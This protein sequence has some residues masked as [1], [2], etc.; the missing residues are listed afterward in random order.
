VAWKSIPGETPIDV[1]GMKISGVAN[2]G[3]LSIVEAENIRKAI[4][5]YFGGPLTRRTAKFD[6]PWMLKLH[7]E[8][9]G[10]VWT[11]AGE[12][13]TANL[14]LGVPWHQIQARMQNLCN[15]LAYW[16]KHWPDSVEQAT[17]LHH[18]AVQ[19]HPFLNGNGRW[20]RLLANIWL[21]LNKQPLT[22]WPEET[23]GETSIIRGE[24]LAAIRAADLG[25]YAP[26]ME[27]HRRYAG[28]GR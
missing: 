14:N 19:I 1:A 11:W 27:L 7:H 13:R 24:Y 9:F 25:D 22:E 8:M 2:R 26:L 12:T 18:R 4:V 10:D 15:D 23:I 6:L 21:K 17:H 5:K 20:S 28:I 16:R 3:Q